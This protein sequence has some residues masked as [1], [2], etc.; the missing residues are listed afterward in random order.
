MG[1]ASHPNRSEITIEATI[2]DKRLLS[3]GRKKSGYSLV[4]FE[5]ADFELAD[6][7]PCK[8]GPAGA[9]GPVSARVS[10]LPWRNSEPDVFIS[11]SCNFTGA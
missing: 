6:F 3:C 1:E 8:F 10:A 11:P 7:S 2:L 5:P 4:I 9:F